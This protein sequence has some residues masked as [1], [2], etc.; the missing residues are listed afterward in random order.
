MGDG[1]E[2]Y[3][4]ACIIVILGTTPEVYVEET[5]YNATMPMYH[6]TTMSLLLGVC[7]KQ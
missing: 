7:G 6:C 2:E 4:V 3:S 5:G 1:G